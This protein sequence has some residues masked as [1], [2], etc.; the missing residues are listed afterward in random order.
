MPPRK[1]K[2]QPEP[3]PVERPAKVRI[4]RLEY[5]GDEALWVALPDGRHWRL[6]RG[7]PIVVDSLTWAALREV[8][9]V[10]ALIAARLILE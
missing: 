4:L 6:R 8:P 3:A 1:P 2:A 10:A 9:E 5:L 7:R